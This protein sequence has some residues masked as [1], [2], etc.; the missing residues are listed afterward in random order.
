MTSLYG[1]RR[2]STLALFQSADL[3]QLGNHRAAPMR[4]VPDP[5]QKSHK[6]SSETISRCDDDRPKNPNSVVP[7][8]G[9]TSP[10]FLISSPDPR[11]MSI[12]PITNHQ[13]P[14]QG[15]RLWLWCDRYPFHSIDAM[16]DVS[17]LKRRGVTVKQR[18]LY[19]GH[20]LQSIAQVSKNLQKGGVWGLGATDSIQ[21]IAQVSKNLK[22][23]GGRFERI[24]TII[25]LGKESEWHHP[26]GTSGVDTGK[27]YSFGPEDESPAM[28]Q[29]LTTVPESCTPRP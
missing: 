15:G 5:S 23:N 2:H 22:K 8:C 28:G 7:E 4:C 9:L 16:P 18:T 19:R 11:S 24:S 12:K 3:N 13:C 27:E 6:A 1:Y 26:V 10:E 25:E 14:F 17:G 20:S 29:T 21:S